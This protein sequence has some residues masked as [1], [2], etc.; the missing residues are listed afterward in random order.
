M[1]IHFLWRSIVAHFNQLVIERND[2]LLVFFAKIN[3]KA[4]KCSCSDVLLN[5]SIHLSDNNDNNKRNDDHL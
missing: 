5:P 1:P 3:I 2:L 4:M